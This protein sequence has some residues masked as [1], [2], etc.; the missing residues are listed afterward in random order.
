MFVLGQMLISLFLSKREESIRESHQKPV[1]YKWQK[2]QDRLLGTLFGKVRYWR[3]YVYQTK[4]GGGYYPVD[5]ELGLTGDGF[6]MMVQSYAA[7]IATKM[8]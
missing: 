4:G 3:S 7:L 2:A 6:S 1:G 8:S 5:M